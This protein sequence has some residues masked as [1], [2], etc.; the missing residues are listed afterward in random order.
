MSHLVYATHGD[1]VQNSIVNGRVLMRNRKVLTMD[2]AAV[3]ADARAW[4]EKIRAAVKTSER[5]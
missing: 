1:D 4:G 3:L 2:Q 5:R